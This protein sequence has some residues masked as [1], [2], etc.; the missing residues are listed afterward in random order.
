VLLQDGFSVDAPPDEVFAYLTDVPQ[1]VPCIPGAELIE[2]V[3]DTRWKGRVRVKVGPISL[4][5]QG[6][7]T[8]DE[9]DEAGRLIVLR[10]QATEQRGKGGL[11]ATITSR[12]EPEGSGS[13]VAVEQDLRVSGQAA[14]VSR[15]MMQDVSARLMRQFAECL[16]QSITA[17]SAPAASAPEAAG[18]TPA[19]TGAADAQAPPP[20]P[21]RAAPE[22]KPLSALALVGVVIRGLLRRLVE[23][24][25]RL[26]GR[27]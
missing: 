17:A 22:T 19:G 12:I 27:R 10:A 15:G 25:R 7:V 4:S 3:D 23:R 5:F 9:R 8:M 13:R 18:A 14:Q 2:T 24:I 20:A 1:V 21:P 11:Q 26:L 16:E 6:T